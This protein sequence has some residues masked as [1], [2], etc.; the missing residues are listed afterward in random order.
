MDEG[1]TMPFSDVRA[2]GA[3]RRD[4]GQ[5]RQPGMKNGRCRMHGGSTPTGLASPHTR[6]GRWSKMMPKRLRSRFELA[7][8]DAELLSLRTEVA[9]LDAKMVGCFEELRDNAGPDS[10]TVLE[11]INDIVEHVK[12]WDSTTAEQRLQALAEAVRPHRDAESTWVEIRS[13][14]NQK[15]KLVMQESRRMIALEQN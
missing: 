4:G 6:S 14:M 15:A 9:A 10:R 11:Q 12:I 2:C 5:C 7:S 1:E 8:N 3:K 13:L